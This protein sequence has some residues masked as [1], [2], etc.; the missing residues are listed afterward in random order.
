MCYFRAFSIQEK[1]NGNIKLELPLPD[2][3]YFEKIGK[4]GKKIL[5]YLMEE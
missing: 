1:G 2:S 4:Q 3:G 5:S